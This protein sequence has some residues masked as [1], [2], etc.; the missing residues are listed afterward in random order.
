MEAASTVWTLDG[1]TIHCVDTR[2]KHHPLLPLL[3]L[4]PLLLIVLSRVVITAGAVAA[5]SVST[6][7][8]F[9]TRVAYLKIFFRCTDRNY[10]QVIY[11]KCLSCLGLLLVVVVAVVVFVLFWFGVFFVFP[12]CFVFVLIFF[13]MIT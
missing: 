13:V 5:A 1:S 7:R 9:R 4:V 6:V 2:W 8:G 12:F 3:P 10:V 11:N